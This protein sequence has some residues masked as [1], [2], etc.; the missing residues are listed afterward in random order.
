MPSFYLHDALIFLNVV[1]YISWVLFSPFFF[2]TLLI[3][4]L[5]CCSHLFT[6]IIRC[7]HV[8]SARPEL[9]HVQGYLNISRF[10]QIKAR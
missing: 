10:D 3:H 2:F 6:F 4:A 8:V 5:T 9:Q 1:V 7:E